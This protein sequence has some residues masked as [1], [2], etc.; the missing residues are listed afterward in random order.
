M[1]YGR[2]PSLEIVKQPYFCTCLNPGR[3]GF[4]L[5]WILSGFRNASIIND[6][7]TAGIQHKNKLLKPFFCLAACK[8]AFHFWTCSP[9]SGSIL[10]GMV[11]QV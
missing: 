3:L 6:H 5:A 9:S 8:S 1:H 7:A 11:V 2:P 10:E 4:L